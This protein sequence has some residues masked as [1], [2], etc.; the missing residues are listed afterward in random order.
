MSGM[1][2]WETGEKPG[3]I[4]GVYDERG[5]RVVQRV[6]GGLL[7]LTA[8]G[9]AGYVYGKEMKRYL[10][11]LLY[12]RYVMS[13]IKGENRLYP[14]AAAEIFSEV[15]RRVKEPYDRWLIRT[16]AE[17]EKRDEYGF[18]RMWNRCVDRYLGELNLK[19]EHSILVKEPGTFLGSLEKDT[20]DHA[21]QDVSKQ[22]GP[23][24]RKAER[25][26]GIKDKS[27][28]LSGCDERCFSHCDPALECGGSM[29][30]SLILRSRQWGSLYPY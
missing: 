2:C 21:L 20:L 10:G 11:R 26:A 15:A 6:I 22:G 3:E 27:G 28:W 14:C 29:N 23:G 4:R 25:G 13:L 5:E 16:A 17:M 7:I 18:A 30:I 1:W 12:F 8:T 19:Y 24:D 9:G